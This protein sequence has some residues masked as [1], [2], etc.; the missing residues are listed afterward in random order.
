M[1]DDEM[2]IFAAR[3]IGMPSPFDSHGVWSA[4]VGDPETGHWWNPLADGGDALS[5]ASK[6]RLEIK[7][8]DGF[9][10]VICRRREDMNNFDMQGMVG[11]GAGTS[12]EPT[13]ENICL[14]IVQAAARIGRQMP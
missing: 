10:Q 8:L 14:A 4:W 13:T 1:S 2:L 5:I 9:K 12:V 3:A 6:L 7:F 11:Y